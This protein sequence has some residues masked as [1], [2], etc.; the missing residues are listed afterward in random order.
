MEVFPLL[1]VKK[2]NAF[3]KVLQNYINQDS[4]YQLTWQYQED[5][6]ELTMTN[7]HSI[8]VHAIAYEELDLANFNLLE[9]QIKSLRNSFKDGDLE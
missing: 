4:E 8:I 2:I 9:Y 1:T 3:E 5:F 7:G 6:L